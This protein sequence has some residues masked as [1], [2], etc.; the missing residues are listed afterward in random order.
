MN[1][2]AQHRIRLRFSVANLLMLM[3]VIAVCLSSHVRERKLRDQAE[4]LRRH[5]DEQAETIEK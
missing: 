2:P 5:V 4:G 1:A 3:A